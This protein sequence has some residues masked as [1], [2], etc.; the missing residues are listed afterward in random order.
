MG[1]G[2]AGVAAGTSANAVFLNPSLLAL[3]RNRD[4]FSLD[5]PVGARLADPNNLMDAVNQFKDSNPI[6]AFKNAI[7]AYAADNSP[8][9]QA[10]VESTGTALIDDLHDIS[11]K[12][13]Q[14][15]GAGA[16]VVGVPG[17]SFG[18]SV[19]ANAYVVGGTL[20]DVTSSDISAIQQV[21]DAANSGGTVTDPTAA[22]TSSV[23]ARF[24][25]V[26]ESGV[27]L[28][29]RFDSLG[30]IAVGLTPKFVQVTTYDYTF[31][32]SGLDNAKIDLDTGK[33]TQSNFN[34]DLGL[35]KDFNNGWLTG[36]SVRNLFAKDYETVQH[37]IFR[38]EPQARLGLAYRHE[39]MT[40]ATDVD[41]TENKPAGFESKT[42]YAIVG[43]EFDVVHLFQL[44]LGYRRNLATLPPGQEANVFSAGIG[45]SPL[46]VHLDAAVAGNSDEI[47]GSLQ[48]GMQF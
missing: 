11:G 14:A 18:F 24:A 30:G 8:A 28:A 10:A 31:T 25:T 47:G 17:D 9:N 22:L 27:G 35:A 19:F 32:G 45:L 13:L 21:I 48:V 4:K 7:D 3:K 1:M 15:E 33:T 5:F 42:R 39:W 44:R 41:L 40:V 23:A 38:I 43:G 20:T 37:N 6:T 12:T 29:H 2:G 36:L 34:M 26:A 16:I 46:G